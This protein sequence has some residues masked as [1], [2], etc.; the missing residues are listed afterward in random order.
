[1]GLKILFLHLHGLLKSVL[2]LQLKH[3]MQAAEPNA[4]GINGED[5]RKETQLVSILYVCL[6]REEKV[7]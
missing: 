7:A 3:E 2:F 5:F 1:M 4:L 6:D